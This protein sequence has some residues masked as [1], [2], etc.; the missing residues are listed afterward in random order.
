MPGYHIDW[1]GAVSAG[2]TAA[3]VFSVV[4]AVFPRL[5][6]ASFYLIA[7][8]LIAVFSLLLRELLRLFVGL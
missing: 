4:S 8:I 7:G 3:V 6:G 2:V 5:K 1:V